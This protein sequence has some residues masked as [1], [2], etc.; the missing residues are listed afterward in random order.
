MT[1]I[2][3]LL[4]VVGVIIAAVAGA[5]GIGHSKGKA[6]A[7]ASATE[8]ETNAAI[9]SEQAVA[10]RQNET[11]KEASDVQSTVTRMSDGD[12]D[13]ELRKEWINKG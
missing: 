5:F 4:T 13:D 11:A 2:Q 12:V 8:R 1:T 10:T 3:L 7:E 9:A 6:K